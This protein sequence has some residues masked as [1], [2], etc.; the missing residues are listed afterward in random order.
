MLTC[1]ALVSCYMSLG[2][3]L[4]IVCLLLTLSYNLWVGRLCTKTLYL[5]KKMNCRMK[6][7]II[8][9]SKTNKHFQRLL[10]PRIW[11]LFCGIHSGNEPVNMKKINWDQPKLLK[12]CRGEGKGFVPHWINKVHSSWYDVKCE[13]ILMNWNQV[14]NYQKEQGPNTLMCVWSRVWYMYK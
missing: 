5:R 8:C 6:K 10:W 3:L 1:P 14:L 4:E 7:K 12:R 11:A 13:Q 2:H 9:R